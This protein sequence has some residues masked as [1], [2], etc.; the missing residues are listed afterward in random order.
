MT[1][2]VFVALGSNLGN[3]AAFLGAARH[4]VSLLPETR[5][6][7][8]SAVEET[9]PFGTG[10]QGPYLNQMLA[11][12]TA[13]HPHALLAT[14]QAIERS[15]GRTRRVHWGARTIDMDIVR[16]GATTHGCRQ[17]TLPHPGLASRGFWRRELAAL[18]ILLAAAA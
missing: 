6:V 9:A 11:L 13:L 17:L 12:R 4:A 16:F 1:D 5:L 2:G 15:L 8:A 3:R 18:E 10:A 7:A 14:L